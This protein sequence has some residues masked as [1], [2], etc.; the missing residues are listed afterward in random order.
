MCVRAR[1]RACVR[2]C[3]CVKGV[4][5]AVKID[6]AGIKTCVFE[7]LH[8]FKTNNYLFTME[9]LRKRKRKRKIPGFF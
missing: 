9:E 1:A 8:F 6:E 7:D 5:K 2:A 4:M 3:V